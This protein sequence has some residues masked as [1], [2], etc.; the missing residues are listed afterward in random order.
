MINAFLL[1][2]APRMIRSLSM[3]FELRAVEIQIPQVTRTVPLRLIIEVRGRRIA[4]FSTRG[5]GFGAHRFAELDD[6]HKAVAA[7]PVNLL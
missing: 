1:N 3:S 6:G 7:G 2:L 4:A 5:H